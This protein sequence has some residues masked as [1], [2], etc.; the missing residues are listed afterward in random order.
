[1][2]LYIIYNHIIYCVAVVHAVTA[3]HIVTAH[4]GQDVELPCSLGDTAGGYRYRGSRIGWI[5]DNMGPYGVNSLH[6]GLLDGYSAHA[7]T[8]SI[9][10]LNIMMNDSRNGTE[11][12]CG[13]ISGSYLEQE[14]DAI[15]VYVAGE[16]H[17]THNCAIN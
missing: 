2:Y 13:L 3:V 6:N 4:P 5:V 11:Y 7:H 15:I 16:F 1:M 10:I 17:F 8:T 12:R 9:I 14:S